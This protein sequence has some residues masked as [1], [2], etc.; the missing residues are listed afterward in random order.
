MAYVEAQTTKSRNREFGKL[1]LT[2]VMLPLTVVVLIGLGR[3]DGLV[4]MAFMGVYLWQSNSQAALM[5]RPNGWQSLAPV[6]WMFAGAGLAMTLFA[7]YSIYTTP[8][9]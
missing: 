5:V 8:G 3:I 2:G 6:F 9:H 4:A 1:L 7:F